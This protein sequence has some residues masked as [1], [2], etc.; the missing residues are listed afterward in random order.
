MQRIAS[1]SASGSKGFTLVELLVVIGI[2]A[3]LIGIL[4]PSLNKARQQAL[5]LKCLSNLRQMGIGMAGYAAAN[6]GYLFYPNTLY[7][8]QRASLYPGSA[9][10]Y[11]EQP[12]LWFNAIVPYLQKK[13][14]TL[15]QTSG[16]AAS[17]IYK[18][19]LQC[20][21]YD[22]FSGPVTIDNGSGQIIQSTTKG[23][24][25]SLKMNLYLQ[26]FSAERRQTTSYVA[27]ARLSRVK[28]QSRF[29]AFADGISMDIVGETPSQF[30]SGQFGF[31]QNSTS[32]T[33]INPRHRGAANIL[34]VDG[35]A[36]SVKQKA[37]RTYTL[38]TTGAKFAVWPSEY[39]DASGQEVN[40]N[41]F[42]TPD[43]QR[44]YRNPAQPLRFSQ[45]DSPL[46]D[47]LYA[48]EGSTP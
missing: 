6:K 45:L 3:I 17:R 19:Y 11:N 35:H 24:T 20:S 15:G 7:D 27:P 37:T 33:W 1:K 34:F 46:A 22:E 42:L 5:T 39:I 26:R 30:D 23:F 47:R 48:P 40:P 28:E 13:E 4:L 2:I 25:R 9:S 21:F 10:F 14:T 31:R 16:V 38:Q 36:D 32:G 8:S 12:T 18:P 43:E 41:P 29:V 44:L